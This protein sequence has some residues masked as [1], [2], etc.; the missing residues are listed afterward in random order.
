MSL[1]GLPSCGRTLAHMK[2]P[3]LVPPFE[4]YLY[5]RAPTVTLASAIVLAEALVKACP[6]FMPPAVQKAVNY[7]ATTGNAAKQ[8][9]AD[10]RRDV[11]TASDE[12][13][14]GL[15]QEADGG[16]SGLRSRLTSY[17]GLPVHRFPKAARAQIIVDSLF[18][19]GGLEFLRDTYVLQWSTMS[20]L[21]KRIDDE[22]LAAEIDDL[23]GPEFLQNIRDIHPRYEA[24]VQGS[25]QRET[26]QE[27]LLVHVR[28]IQR[29]V[30]AYA[31]QVCA[32]VDDADD[33]TIEAARDA[34]AAID[35]MRVTAAN[36]RASGD[37]AAKG[38]VEPAVVE[39]SP[40]ID[41]ATDVGDKTK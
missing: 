40:A 6:G 10:R 8:A 9:W 39:T 31:T 33:A 30:V 19:E 14:R 26:S 36:K 32:T 22:G 24:M 13:S 1:D 20:V 5:T 23:A 3:K 12:S 29:A 11:G 16:W 21:L 35:T 28:L 18:G 7:L 4:P 38:A 27:S 34:L 37:E 41:A 17:A 15:D 2:T 25:L